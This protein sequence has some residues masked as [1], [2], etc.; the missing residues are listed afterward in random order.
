MCEILCYGGVIY[1]VLEVS[2]LSQNNLLQRIE[3][4]N[5]IML[6]RDHWCG[7]TSLEGLFLRIF[8]LAEDKY[9]SVVN[10]GR[11]VEDRW[12]WFGVASINVWM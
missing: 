10:M 2:F 3:I 1:N 12:E 4:S 6:W 11:W 9:Y 7:P 5:P 8:Q